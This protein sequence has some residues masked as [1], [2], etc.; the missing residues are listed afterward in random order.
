[1]THVVNGN[2]RNCRYTDCVATCP[3]ACFHVD[4]V[5][6]YIDPQVC[7]DCSACVPACP[8]HAIVEDIDLPESER[9]W[10]E[11]NA[12]SAQRYPALRAKLPRLPG[13]DERRRELGY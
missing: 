11:I 1:M 4:E 8:V 6:A 13:A 2:C 9:H 7:I 3:V 12:E 10:L 5:R